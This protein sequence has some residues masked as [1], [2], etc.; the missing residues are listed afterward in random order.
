MAP[1]YTYFSSRGDVHLR[2]AFLAFLAHPHYTLL[3]STRSEITPRFAGP[4]AIVETRWKGHGTWQEGAFEDDQRCSM[5]WVRDGA[6]W[7][8]LSEHC[9]QIV[10]APAS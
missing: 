4:T 3:A 5:V 10:P 9:T 7:K 8:V 6:A 2:P 1:E